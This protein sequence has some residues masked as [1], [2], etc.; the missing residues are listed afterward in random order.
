MSLGAHVLVFNL[1]HVGFVLFRLSLS[2]VSSHSAAWACAKSLTIEDPKMPDSEL[3]HLLYTSA[4]H[5]RNLSLE[6]IPLRPWLAR[7]L[8]NNCVALKKFCIALGH[9]GPESG[10]INDIWSVVRRLEVFEISVGEFSVP[11]LAR[12][13]GMAPQLKQLNLQITLPSETME[14]LLACFPNLQQVSLGALDHLILLKNHRKLERVDISSHRRILKNELSSVPFQIIDAHNQFV[15]AST[16]KHNIIF[17]GE[18]LL[19]CALK[20]VSPVG[21]IAALHPQVPFGMEIVLASFGRRCG[22]VSKLLGLIGAPQFSSLFPPLQEVLQKLDYVGIVEDLLKCQFHEGFDIQA[23]NHYL[24]SA[25]ISCVL[26]SLQKQL[27]ELL[28]ID[29]RRANLL[30][31]LPYLNS[32]KL[33]VLQSRGILRLENVLRQR[34]PEGLSLAHLPTTGAEVKLMQIALGRDVFQEIYTDPESNNRRN[35]VENPL[36]HLW[37][38]DCISAAAAVMKSIAPSAYKTEQL[39]CI[40]NRRRLSSALKSAIR[41][42]QLSWMQSILDATDLHSIRPVDLV[43]CLWRICLASPKSDDGSSAPVEID[44]TDISP[45]LQLLVNFIKKEEIYLNLFDPTSDWGKRAVFALQKYSSPTTLPNVAFVI[46]EFEECTLSQYYQIVDKAELHELCYNTAKM[47]L[48]SKSAAEPDQ[49]YS[50]KLVDQM[51]KFC[52]ITAQRQLEPAGRAAAV[53]NELEDLLDNDFGGWVD[54]RSPSA[55]YLK[56]CFE[57]E[58]LHKSPEDFLEMLSWLLQLEFGIVE[59]QEWRSTRRAHLLH[60][61]RDLMPHYIVSLVDVIR[62]CTPY[63]TT[64]EILTKDPIGRN[65]IESVRCS[66]SPHCDVM[67]QILES[68]A[69]GRQSRPTTDSRSE[70]LPK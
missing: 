27:S 35:G 45:F 13:I 3:Q 64:H 15:S 24:L 53:G 23:W 20:T 17:C 51:K 59:T 14:Q 48:I 41:S 37:D 34:S 28:E 33:K 25:D 40:R 69:T 67:M 36:L 38:C 2:C 8:S 56:R 54:F 5:L 9:L 46:T 42:N 22:D 4:S 57:D 47:V 1:T 70:L 58:R 50:L 60:E 44:L 16:L 11:H 30:W 55:L 10:D 43:D 66:A 39:S 65:L 19:T 29:S 21:L 63:L 18:T 61:L 6:S 31:L 62:I 12:A 26:P 68:A 52:E 7:L 32:K 49:K